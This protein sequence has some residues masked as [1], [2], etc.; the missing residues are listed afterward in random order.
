MNRSDRKKKSNRIYSTLG[1]LALLGITSFYLVQMNQSVSIDSNISQ[2][3]GNWAYDYSAGLQ[4]RYH[5]EFDGGG[6]T[7]G[8]N[9]R[10][11]SSVVL[12]SDLFITSHGFSKGAY[13]VE[14]RLGNVSHAEIWS[15]EKELLGGSLKA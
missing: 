15:N 4:H 8:D 5:L 2:H 9:E 14:Y 13:S 1:L 11:A 7:L 6:E 3:S 10:S 12:H